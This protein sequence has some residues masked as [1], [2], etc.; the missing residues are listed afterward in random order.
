MLWAVLVVTVFLVLFAFFPMKCFMGVGG[1]S[2]KIFNEAPVILIKAIL[3]KPKKL[4][5]HLKRTLI[6]LGQHS[7]Y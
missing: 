6:I 4:R 2:S 7:V 5:T 1:K 3:L